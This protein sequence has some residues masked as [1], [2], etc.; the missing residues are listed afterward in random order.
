MQN[1]SAVLSGGY[2]RYMPRYVSELP[3][4][5][6]PESE[7]QPFIKLVDYILFIKKQPFY[8]STDLNFAEERLMSN[9]FENLID[10]LVYE[11]YFPEELHE[12]KKQ[13]M[14]LIIKENLPDLDAIEG[15][16]V[17]TLKQI[18]RRLT[19]KNHPLYNN[20]FFLDSVPVV[21]IIEGKA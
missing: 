2:Y 3:I 5:K 14:N 10:A 1:T 4:P 17:S 8:N 15:D 12:A 20:L 16:K 21:R 6:I 19:D 11:L 7:Q 13:F 9:F 18:V